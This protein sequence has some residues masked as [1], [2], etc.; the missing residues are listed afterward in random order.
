[1]L[2][3]KKNEITAHLF[4]SYIIKLEQSR[5]D[6]LEVSFS[7]IQTPE[8]GLDGSEGSVHYLVCSGVG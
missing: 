8:S 7:A 4:L 3:I 1:M 5:K 6:Y 2:Y